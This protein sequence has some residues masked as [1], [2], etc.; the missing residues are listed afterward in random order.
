ME[1]SSMS[2]RN[3]RKRSGFTLIEL[4][5]VIAIMGVLAGMLMNGVQKAREAAK[6]IECANN[7]RNIGFAMHNQESAASVL[8]TE[9]AQAGSSTRE[10]FYTKILS[11]LEANK[12]SADIEA[13]GQATQNIKTFLCPSRRT[14]L[15]APKGR[16]YGYVS[17][18]TGGSSTGKQAVLDTPGGA[19]IT[20]ISNA[21]GTSNTAVISH[22]WMDPTKYGTVGTDT[23]DSKSPMNYVQGSGS[24]P[25]YQDNNQKGQGGMGSPHPSVMPFLFADNHTA[26]LSYG[27]WLNTTYQGNQ[28]PNGVLTFNY[29]NQK[30]TLNF[31]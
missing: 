30:E 9:I 29:L 15:Q 7:L 18:S 26:N 13:G 4:L 28:T 14:P 22:L 25:F 6:R 16:D 27:S 31:P 19:S 23:Y 11:E 8:P 24:V 2:H 3:P 20:V 1:V 5:V 17:F 10:S 21:Q 12:A